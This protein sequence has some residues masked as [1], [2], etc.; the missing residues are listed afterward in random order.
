MIFFGV[1][2]LLL[3]LCAFILAGCAC[4]SPIFGR[5]TGYK[6]IYLFEVGQ[7]SSTGK[8][9]CFRNTVYF[10]LVRGSVVTSSVIGFIAFI[11]VILTILRGR[12]AFL[13]CLS[14]CFSFIAFLLMALCTAIMSVEYFVGFCSDDG[15]SG[16]KPLKGVFKLCCGFYLLVTSCA[17]YLGSLIAQFF[18]L[19]SWAAF[20]NEMCMYLE[21]L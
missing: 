5:A 11:V 19:L 12:M 15:G 9:S 10:N 18:A 17:V 16:K 7:A 13:M 2:S 1:L 20:L 8:D 3:T 14:P 4:F 6:T 21:E